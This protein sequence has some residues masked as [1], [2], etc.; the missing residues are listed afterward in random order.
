MAKEFFKD[1]PNTTTPLTA[2]RLNGLL[3]GEEAMG[4]L[5]VDS[6][7]SSN[8]FNYTMTPV[9]Y[10]NTSVSLISPNGIKVIA[11]GSG[12]TY[13]TA[14]YKV[15]NTGDYLG[16]TI[17]LTCDVSVGTGA[18]R[19]AMGTCDSAGGNRSMLVSKDISS[20]GRHSITA[21]MPSSTTSTS[22]YLYVAFNVSRGTAPTSGNYCDFTNIQLNTGE[23]TTYTPYQNLSGMET[24]ST[25]EQVVGTWIDGKP[26]YRKVISYT[27]S[28]TIG[29]VGQVTNISVP[30]GISN[31]GTTINLKLLIG[32]IYPAPYLDGD[33]TKIT[34]A[35]WISR[36]D[37]TNV[38]F[39][40]MNDTWS[41]R[42]SYLILEYTKTTD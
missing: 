23:D 4:N 25:N 1:L 6:I 32:G 14:I 3:D 34:K 35:T 42:T 33:G 31:L 20:N 15:L 18:P 8:L 22:K 10:A 11:G 36:L 41:A 28:S 27:N 39:R 29:G 37:N 24:Y 21:T 40:I 12:A 26:I 38:I 2:D 16:Q 17:T 19:I 13:S 30:H 7:R 5:V 9:Y